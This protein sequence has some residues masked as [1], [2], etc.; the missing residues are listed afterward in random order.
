METLPPRFFPPTWGVDP[1][2]V[3]GQSEL[4]FPRHPLPLVTVWFGI[5]CGNM[6][7]TAQGRFWSEGVLG[8][9]LARSLRT[10]S[11]QELYC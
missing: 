3:L 7:K 5:L 6:D 10:S 11:V 1:D 9:A 2:S 4:G 8:S